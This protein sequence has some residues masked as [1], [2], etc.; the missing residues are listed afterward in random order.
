MI[1]QKLWI[2]VC[3]GDVSCVNVYINM[4]EDARNVMPC[5]GNV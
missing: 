2:K 4:L 1:R 3:L 5:R